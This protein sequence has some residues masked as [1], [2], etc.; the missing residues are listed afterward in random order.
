MADEH[1]APPRDLSW[2]ERLGESPTAWS[3]HVAL[4][5]FDA[6]YPENPR[7]GEAE[8]A[9]REPVR[10][11]QLPSSAFEP[12]E[13]T[14]FTPAE[15]ADGME[16]AAKAR[17]TI[18]FLGLWGPN[19]PLPTHMTEYARERLR[20]A[21]DATLVRF[22][23]IFHH[24]MMLL[25]H[26]AWSKNEPTVAMDRPESDAFARYL[27]AL[28]G[29]G[30]PSTRN[31]DAAHDFSKFYNAGWLSTSCRSPDGLRAIVADHFGV[32]TTVEEFVGEWLDLPESARFRLA[33]TPE[34]GLLGK[35]C[36]LGARV[37]SRTHKFRLTLGPLDA[38]QFEQMLPNSD[39][40]ATLAA[41]VRLYTN[42]EWDCEL[43]LLVGARAIQPM[44][45][46]GGGRLGWTTR[47][48]PPAGVEAELVID[49]ILQRTRR[50]ERGPGVRRVEEV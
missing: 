17:L 9:S 6:A 11:G 3:F 41:I 31:R 35:T 29:L 13:V 7:L 33:D 14:D 36:V 39:A 15:G 45:L 4:R 46:C 43:S 18:G 27:G 24:R 37:W 8:R 12:H 40:I 44:R 5:R 23:D 47:I 30:L 19:G 34:T 2:L 49:P 20:H 16:R 42:D 10:L 25:F 21:G 38:L 28:I 50:V 48:G 26:R 22:A 1:R 32:P